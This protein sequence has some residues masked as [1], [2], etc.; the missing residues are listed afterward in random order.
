MTETRKVGESAKPA[1]NRGKGR[2]K[3]V[4]NK[5]NAALKD[6]ILGALGNAG[7]VDYLVKQASENPVAFMGL[8]GRVLPLDSNVNH[9]GTVGIIR[10]PGL[11]E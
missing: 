8:V 3:G 5:V 6:M 10:Y 4:P 11:D 7:G 2:P 9:S 1:G